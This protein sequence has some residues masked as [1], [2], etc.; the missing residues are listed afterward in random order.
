MGRFLVY[1][2]RFAIFLPRSGDL[3]AKFAANFARF[4][5]SMAQLKFY[6]SRI[7]LCTDRPP[8]GVLHSAVDEASKKIYESSDSIRESLL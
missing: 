1:R 6:T 3:C 7:E 2:E 4:V 5:L 8:S